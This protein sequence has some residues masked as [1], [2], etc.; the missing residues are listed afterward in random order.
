MNK[1]H[2]MTDLEC[3]EALLRR[4]KAERVVYMEPNSKAI[5]AVQAG[6]TIHD[7]YTSPIFSY[8]T[9]KR[10]AE[11]IGWIFQP[12]YSSIGADFG[13]EVKRLEKTYGQAPA[14]VDYAV[15][16]EDDVWKLTLPDLK[17]LV[18]VSKGMEFCGISASEKLDNQYF[19]VVFNCSGPFTAA[20]EIC[21]IDRLAR[22]LVRKPE[23]VHHLLRLA[24]DH[25]LQATLLW[26]DTFKDSNLLFYEGEPTSSNQIISS[27]H[28]KQFALPYIKELHEK[29]LSMGYKH[30]MCHICGDH[31]ANLQYWSQV[32]MGKPGIV[33][34]GEEIDLETAAGFFPHDVI[35]GNLN[36]ATI[37][38]GTPRQ[39]YLAAKKVLLKGKKS[40]RYIFGR[41]C[42]LP[43]MA[44]RENL[45]AILAAIND[46][47]WYD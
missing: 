34:F 21:G 33:S 39:V 17:S 8:R 13:G 42:E 15:E 23:V 47:G 41:G 37:Q 9:Q 5:A 11:D 19:N 3:M 26:L 10:I 43:P 12:S 40:G 4:E 29:V 44:S 25:I 30:I 18:S 6:A 20:G 32:P 46:F 45:K 38:T 28:F 27:D 35:Y 22:W 36:P 16:T 24:T 7:A 14:L 31:N 2:N 1:K